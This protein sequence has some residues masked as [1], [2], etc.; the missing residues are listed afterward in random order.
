MWPRSS[1][2]EI[3]ELLP[4]LRF[5]E[6]TT[7]GGSELAD[8]RSEPVRDLARESAEHLILKRIAASFFT[9]PGLWP[10]LWPVQ[11]FE[12]FE[13][14]AGRVDVAI[15]NLRIACECGDMSAHRIVNILLAGWSAVIVPFPKGDY[16][17]WRRVKVYMIA[18][19]A[20]GLADVLTKI[21]AAMRRCADVLNLP[22]LRGL[23]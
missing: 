11:A 7:I 3:K 15:P 21:R 6:R 20:D 1:G 9:D 13:T 4:L 5:M 22:P 2:D 17:Q 10:G 23:Q 18:A 8:A 14:G 16:T 12:E 19:D